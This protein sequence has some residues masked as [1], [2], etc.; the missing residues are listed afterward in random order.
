MTASPIIL[1]PTPLNEDQ[2]DCLGKL[3]ECLTEAKKGNIYTVGIV[4]CMKSGFATTIGGSDAG[5][6][7]LG[8]DA[9]KQRILE[10]VTDEGDKR[11]PL[12]H[13]KPRI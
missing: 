10:R 3:E 7:N 12:I 11:S 6:L 4:V 8:C 13:L 1:S 9:L 2:L 5:S